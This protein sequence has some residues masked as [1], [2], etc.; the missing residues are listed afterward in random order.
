[1]AYAVLF[2]GLYLLWSGFSERK[3]SATLGKLSLMG[4]GFIL[5]I[6][7]TALPYYLQGAEAIWWTS[8]FKAPLAYSESKQHSLLKTLPAILVI[9]GLLL[10]GFT[11]KVIDYK[12]KQQQLLATAAIGVSVSFMQAG[13]VN[14]HYL[15][16]LYP[17]MLIL[18]GIAIGKLPRPKKALNWVIVAVLALIPTEAYMEYANIISH[19]RLK[20]VH[21][22]MVRELMFPTTF[23]TKILKLKT[24]SSLNIILDI[25]YWAYIPQP[26]WPPIQVI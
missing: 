4:A 20:R 3:H 2:L 10:A 22:I 26:R 17:F 19:T 6:L 25:G 5:L 13:K 18:I 8:I 14:G 1:M 7:L 11:S 9:L 21:F 23:W 12:S 15:I 16:Q 24:S